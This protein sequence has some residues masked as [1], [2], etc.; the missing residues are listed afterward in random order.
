MVKRGVLHLNEP[1]SWRY[2]PLLKRVI[3]FMIYVLKV[4]QLN[5]FLNRLVSLRDELAHDLLKFFLDPLCSILE[6]CI[7]FDS[8]V[9]MFKILYDC[10]LSLILL[11]NLQLLIERPCLRDVVVQ[12]LA[13]M[14]DCAFIIWECS[15]TFLNAF[16]RLFL[17]A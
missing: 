6:I 15:L 5:I 11:L 17:V 10:V 12:S 13:L 1:L 2:P 16:Q 3:I 8:C 9:I 7:P 4:L 14:Q